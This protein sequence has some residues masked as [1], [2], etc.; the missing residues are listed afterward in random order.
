MVELVP[1]GIR[2]LDEILL[3]GIIRNNTV[4]VKGIAGSGKTLLGIQFVYN[5][6][7]SFDEPGIVVSFE[8]NPEKFHQDAEGFGWNLQELH[9]AG[10]LEL[11]FTSPEVLQTELDDPQSLLLQRANE[12]QA[13]RIF[14]D[15]VSLFQGAGPMGCPRPAVGDRTAACSIR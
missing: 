1:T 10:R 9:D 14:I 12:I 2:G 13:R 5:G 15:T 11:I 6:A 7:V 8:A 3:G 4:L